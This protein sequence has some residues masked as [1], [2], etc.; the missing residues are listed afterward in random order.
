MRL[1]VTLGLSLALS[2][3]L[4][5]QTIYRYEQLTAGPTSPDS[6]AA[7]TLEPTG[8]GAMTFCEMEVESF[9]MRYRLDGTTATNTV[10][11]S[12]TPADAPI[13]LSPAQAS[14]LSVVG[15]ASS[16]TG[17]VNVQCGQ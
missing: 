12:M 13:R 17:L 9:S 10:G 4:W 8:I 6:L 7:E 2:L 15:Y 3:G 1:L 14:R 11:M 16:G 5:A